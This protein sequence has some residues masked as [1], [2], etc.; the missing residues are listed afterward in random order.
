[1]WEF[2][3]GVY[4]GEWREVESPV[5]TPLYDVVSTQNGPAAVGG[6]GKVIGRTP[7]GEWG[8]LVENGPAGKSRALRTV[9]ATDDGKRIWFAGDA[10]S[11]GYY[12]LE[13][14]ERNN[15]TNVDTLGD[16][17][18]SETLSGTIGALTVAG[19]RG[20]E[21]LLF[22]DTSG[23]ILPAH[24]DDKQEG[25]GI[26]I[27][28]EFTSSPSGDTAVKAITSDTDGVGYAV[29]NNARIY[30]TT[31][32]DGWEQI[33]I[34]DVGKSMYSA[35]VDGEAILVGGGGGFLYEREGDDRWTPHNVGSFTVR[36]MTRADGEMLAGG[37]GHLVYR[38]GNSKWG[39]VPWHGGTT[40]RGIT[41]GQGEQ[42]DVA[43]CKNGTIIEGYRSDDD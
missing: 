34:H 9:D 31:A 25:D 43:V 42:E 4:P 5:G 32:D 27:D 33:G 3:Q 10:K 36:A 26:Q 19:D 16:N 38:E 1:M 35:Y 30:K 28:W 11:I 13:S 22:A 14:R 7:D 29:D 15:Y 39:R 20:N 41:V 6:K 24:M 40:I 12:D 18:G 21:K 8:V 37:A 23:N 17:P 2:D